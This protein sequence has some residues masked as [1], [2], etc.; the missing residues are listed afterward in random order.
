MQRLDNQNTNH[1]V[2][3]QDRWPR[4]NV[5]GIYTDDYAACTMICSYLNAIPRAD[6]RR[7]APSY[8]RLAWNFI[9]V[10]AWSRID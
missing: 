1:S 7:L 4:S 5:T 2:Y 6:C 9:R 3:G 8:L 10:L